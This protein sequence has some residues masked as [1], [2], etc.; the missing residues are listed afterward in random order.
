M[1]RAA[2]NHQFS[3][4]SVSSRGTLHVITSHEPGRPDARRGGGSVAR[5][6][7][8]GSSAGE[9]PDLRAAGEA[10]D[11]SH[12]RGDEAGP[13]GKPRDAGSGDRASNAGCGGH[14]PRSGPDASSAGGGHHPDASTSNADR[15]AGAGHACASNA[16]RDAGHASASNADRDA[17]AD[18]ARAGANGPQLTGT[19]HPTSSD[20]AR[21]DRWASPWRHGVPHPAGGS[22]V[23]GRAVAHRGGARADDPSG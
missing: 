22:R 14:R 20:D 18:H 23:A 19:N 1:F 6:R 9:S 13:A 10:R 8:A 2:R 11:T 21:A 12:A 5:G 16:D 7:P 15:G 3:E 4:G 17:G